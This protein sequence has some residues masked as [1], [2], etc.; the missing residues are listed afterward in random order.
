MSNASFAFLDS[1][2]SFHIISLSKIQLSKRD[3][4]NNMEI[5]LFFKFLFVCLSLSHINCET[6]EESVIHGGEEWEEI[7]PVVPVVR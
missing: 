1:R 5:L 4:A 6:G 7:I 2:I 3:L